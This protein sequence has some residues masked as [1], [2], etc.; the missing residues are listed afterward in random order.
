[1]LNRPL[2]GET[3]IAT[4]TLFPKL[5][6]LQ[7]ERLIL[8]SLDTHKAEDI[9]SIDLTGKSDFADRMV[10]ASGTSARHVGSLADHV[11]EALKQAG[12]E[13]VP[14]EGKDSCDW[15]L[16]DAGDIVVHIFHPEARSY[17]N[18]EKM[19]SVSVP[20]LEVAY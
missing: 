14:V 20:Q 3:A 16:V 9:V 7:L 8:S 1:L 6:L 15:V 18:L 10:V 13:H 4:K 17:Y 2:K 19:W 5:S 12:Y 11:V